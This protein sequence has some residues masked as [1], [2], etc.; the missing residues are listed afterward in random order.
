[1]TSSSNIQAPLQYSH[2]ASQAVRDILAERQRQ[3]EQE[4]FTP[5]RDDA[6][7]RARQLSLAAY[8]Y[9]G[10]YAARAWAFAQ[11]LHHE[12]RTESAPFTWPW[13]EAWWK[14][15]SPRRDLVRAAALLIAEIERLDREGSPNA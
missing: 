11:G 3:V 4:G 14:P 10:H 8:S 9:I 5:S 1:M 2:E 12:Y 6:G 13:D 7:H 15:K